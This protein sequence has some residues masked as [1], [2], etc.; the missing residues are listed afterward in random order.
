MPFLSHIQTTILYQRETLRELSLASSCTMVKTLKKFFDQPD[1]TWQQFFR[2][3]DQP[4][5]YCRIE[6]HTS[7]EV[8]EILAVLE[9][10]YREALPQPNLRRWSGSIYTWLTQSFHLHLV[11]I[12]IAI[13]RICSI[14]QPEQPAW[15]CLLKTI[16]ALYLAPA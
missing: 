7:E 15:W 9:K 13:K 2:R 5:P 6:G 1:T 10:V 12:E 16:G 11:M 8:R 3:L 14:V 4:E